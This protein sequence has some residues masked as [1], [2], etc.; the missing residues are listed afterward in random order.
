[1]EH[2]PVPCTC[3]GLSVFC[4]DGQIFWSSLSIST[5]ILVVLSLFTFPQVYQG[6]KFTEQEI[7]Y[8]TAVF[9]VCLVTIAA[10]ITCR[11]YGHKMDKTTTKGGNNKNN[12]RRMMHKLNEL[13][14]GIF[15]T[16]LGKQKKRTV[17]AEVTV[18]QRSSKMAPEIA[19][20]VNMERFG[21][22][23]N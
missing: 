9:A 18:Y 5:T 17:L 23:Q 22:Q 2:E 7:V 6:K 15:Q 19:M 4:K 14:A 8:T 11:M 16:V 1:M 13:C 21:T 12:I 20:T 3:R 10:A